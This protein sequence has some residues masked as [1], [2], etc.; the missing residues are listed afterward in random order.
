MYARLMVSASCAVAAV[1][2]SGCSGSS[3]GVPGDWSSTY[4]PPDIQTLSSSWTRTTC[5]IVEFGLWATGCRSYEMD[6]YCKPP[7]VSI[8]TCQDAPPRSLASGPRSAREAFHFEDCSSFTP[9]PMCKVG[10]F[11]SSKIS[12]C[13]YAAWA[14][15]KTPAG[16]ACAY[17]WTPEAAEFHESC[18]DVNTYHAHSIEALRAIN[19]TVR[20]ACNAE[21]DIVSAQGFSDSSLNTVF[22]RHPATVNGQPIY[23]DATQQRYIFWCRHYNVLMISDVKW[24]EINDQGQCAALAQGPPS[25]G[26]IDGATWQE[27]ALEWGSGS[28]SL[29]CGL[30]NG[31]TGLTNCWQ[32][33]VGEGDARQL[34]I[35][36]ASQATV[37]EGVSVGQGSYLATVPWAQSSEPRVVSA[38][39]AYQV[40][41]MTGGGCIAALCVL[42]HRFTMSAHEAAADGEYLQAAS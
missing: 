26:L 41:I 23:M 10:G 21:T 28:A 1:I 9:P 36:L 24:R 5:Q 34:V 15:V 37:S 42:R 14:K 32:K 13:R 35:W 11:R 8:S 18:T 22:F 20:N 40:A 19:G 30:L 12:H 16:E 39:F 27:E 4:A 17:A 38:G 2:L 6:Y 31:Q 29:S 33:L 25:L 3:T 7:G